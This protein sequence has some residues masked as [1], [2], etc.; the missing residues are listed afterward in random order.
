[1]SNRNINDLTPNTREKYLKFI[2][3]ARSRYWYSVFITDGLRTQA[4]QNALY[5]Q[6]RTTP[7]PIVTWT[8]NSNHLYWIAFDVA[9][10]A[11]QQLYPEIWGIEWTRLW[12]IAE[13]LDLDRW[14]AMRGIDSPHF[15]NTNDTPLISVDTWNPVVANNAT[16]LYYE[17]IS[18]EE[19][20]WS[21]FKY[22]EDA[23]TRILALPIEQ[24]V[25]ELI[26]LVNIISKRTEDHFID[27]W[28]TLE[29]QCVWKSENKDEIL[30]LAWTGSIMNPI[31]W[32]I[33]Y[34]FIDMHPWLDST[35]QQ[36]LFNNLFT[37][38]ADRL[39]PIK[40]RR[41]D[42][43][44]MIKVNFAEDWD[45]DLPV[46]FKP[47]S[48]AYAFTPWG[49]RQWEIYVNLNKN[50]TISWT[51]KLL[52]VLVHELLHS[53]GFEHSDNPESI[54]YYKNLTDK[55]IFLPQDELLDMR[56]LYNLN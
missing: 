1:M 19:W 44:W 15:Q 51:N 48:L 54:L 47:Q 27:T 14:Y 56:R 11:P 43:N 16:S 41:V 30:D 10:N 7:W 4:E 12:E 18:K 20:S 17:T 53:L 55:W 13:E 40:F 26:D 38:I 35:K 42:S 8:T 36:I 50:I 23:K 31:N 39:K 49:S 25:S 5:A 52:K 6:G 22:P 32:E 2:E 46:P 3:L 21:I 28:H 45:A 29:Y 34:S 24:Q 9:F 37:Y 33:T